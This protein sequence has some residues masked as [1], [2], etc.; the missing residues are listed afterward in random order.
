MN[1]L[2]TITGIGILAM[3]SEIFSFR[4]ALF[5]LVLIGLFAALGFAILD[6]NT[7]VRYFSD[8]MY[9]DN[10]AIAFSAVTI[11]TTVLWFLL[12]SGY[13][14]GNSH[15]T[16]YVSLILFSLAGAVVMISYADLTM[17]FIG[18][19]IL[20]ISMYIMA[21][22]NKS[23]LRS[24]ESGFKYF[25]LGAFATGFLLFGIAL[26][27]GATGSFN[28]QEIS[29]YVSANK[30]NLPLIVYAGILLMMVGLIFKISAA[31]FHFWAPDVYE[32]APSPVTA[33][34]S[35]VVKTAAFAAFLRLFIICFSGLADWW[36]PLLAICSALS[37]VAGNILAVYQKSIKR[38]LAY[39]SIS[40]A[41][42][43]LMSIVAMNEISDSS[44]FIYTAAYSVSSIGIFTLVLTMSGAGNESIASLKGFASIHK[45]PALFIS[46]ILLSLS[47]IPPV[48]GFFGKYYVFT[49]ALKSEYT[50]LV[51]LAVLSSL[52]GVYYYF[53]VIISMYQPAD[54]EAVQ[55]EFSKMHYLVL[56]IAVLL[57]LFIGL[58]PGFLVE[59][60]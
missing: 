30:S 46:I 52:I 43:M 41:G 18:L 9:F 60:L 21:S 14:R 57:T 27:Y 37:M 15:E 51:L 6:W 47:G 10:Y 20:S 28:L 48:A 42:Y 11:S 56:L 50:W 5:P 25:M 16:D 35:T 49:A 23:D 54:R 40:H 17:L 58:A 45:T 7:N 1:T 4:K 8:M 34:M 3:L 44:L 2:I 29:G 33:Y 39:S 24:N 32:G 53:K 22:A 36:G 12:S 19:E 26:I 31:P 59:L 55:L 38:M 13:L